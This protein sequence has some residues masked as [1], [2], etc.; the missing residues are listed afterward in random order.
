M[1]KMKL[2][3]F[4]SM[5]FLFS[6]IYIA[7]ILITDEQIEL[8][9]QITIE[10]GDTLWSLAEQYS[11][12]MA[13]HDWINAVKKEN[14]LSGEH[15]VSG[16]TLIVPIEKNSKYIAEINEPI[17]TQSIKVARENNESK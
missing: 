6:F 2:N 1:K 15:V 16:Q 7:F 13:K 4:T 17:H 9:E 11:G 12:K 8:Y 14:A 3:S 10:Q 5:F